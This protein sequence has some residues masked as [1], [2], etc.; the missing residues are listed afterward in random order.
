MM[1]RDVPH[2]RPHRFQV[3]MQV[4]DAGDKILGDITS[5]VQEDARLLAVINDD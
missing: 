3:G 5:I 2:Q 4:V 1:K